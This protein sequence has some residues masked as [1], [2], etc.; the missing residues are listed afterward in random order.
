M[1]H[2]HMSNTNAC[3][4]PCNS[5][6]EVMCDAYGSKEREKGIEGEREEKE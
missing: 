5:V 6:D 3:M 2:A 4:L 1:G